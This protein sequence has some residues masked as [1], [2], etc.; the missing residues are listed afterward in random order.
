MES[1]VKSKEISPS[2]RRWVAR[3]VRTFFFR[4]RRGGPWIVPDWLPHER[5]E[6][7]GNT[8]A[9]LAGRWFP[10]KNARGV[11]VL[12]HP[13]RRYGQHWFVLSG[14][15]D[16]LHDR[17]FHLLTFDFPDYGESRGGATYY[18]EDVLAACH[19][20]R[21][22]VSDLPLHVVGISL[23]AFAAANAA[24]LLD[25]VDGLVLESPYPTFKDW[26]GHRLGRWG[27]AAFE[28]MFPHTATRIRADRNLAQARARRILVA[29][30]SDDETTPPELSRRV[31]ASAPPD[32]S[33]YLEVSGIPHLDL[34]SK[35]PT[36]RNAVLATLGDSNVSNGTA[37]PPTRSW[38]TSIDAHA[39]ARRGDDRLDSLGLLPLADARV[40]PREASVV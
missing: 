22:R 26:Y 34:F 35:S 32:R 3:L 20:A 21:G 17:G 19:A 6:L 2:E 12:C 5:L 38:P 36:Y 14:W 31:A 29:A 10:A 27:M 40:P 28:Q 30:A 25:F 15:I 37:G 24:P 18:Y 1:T 33:R 23:G 7:E 8:G 9:R 4:D 39:P 16:F 13:D 11:V